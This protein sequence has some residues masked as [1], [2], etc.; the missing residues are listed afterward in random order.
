MVEKLRQEF[1]EKYFTQ[2]STTKGIETMAKEMGL[3]KNSLRRFLGKL[4]ENITFRTSTLNLISER[5]GYENYH[6]FSNPIKENSPIDFETLQI[7][8]NTVK[9]KGIIVEADRFHKANYHFAKKIFSNIE[10][11]KKFIQLFSDNQEALEYVLAW[12]PDYSKIH[13]KN[14]QNILLL[15]SK[16]SKQTHIK[17]FSHSFIFF[18]KFMSENL[19]NNEAE[20]IIGKIEKYAKKMKEEGNSWGFP[21]ARLV[22]AKCI[23]KYFKERKKEEKES[24]I[25][26]KIEKILITN[27]PKNLEF[28]EKAIYHIYVSDSLN[29]LGFYEK[30]KEMID[31]LNP[32][33]IIFLIKKSAQYEVQIT[34]WKVNKIITLFHLHQK[35]E[36]K[37]LF[38][39]ITK[40]FSNPKIFTFDSKNYVELKYYFI[41]QK[42]FPDNEFYKQKFCH[43]VEKTKFTFFKKIA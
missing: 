23:Y 24:I 19:N 28:Q 14:Y 18:G 27:Y 17:V 40:E 35:E 41:A 2:V 33:N 10:N 37:K 31:F 43:L 4:D 5:L 11:L 38:K 13:D 42:L 21:E 20:A 16:I 6:D 12:H 15:F 7:Y 26:Q 29:N 22:I 34:L 30:A 25:N 32:K 9:D 3:S 36:A 39:E 8:Y 1:E